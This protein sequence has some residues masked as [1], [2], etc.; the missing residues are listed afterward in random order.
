MDRNAKTEF[1]PIIMIGQK[2]LDSGEQNHEDTLG[3]VGK[4]SC[5]ETGQSNL[6]GW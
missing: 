3:N 6:P 1:L 4:R 5:K 2:P